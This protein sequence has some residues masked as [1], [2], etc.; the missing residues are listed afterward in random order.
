MKQLKD[1]G[2]KFFPR[3]RGWSG[4]DGAVAVVALVFPARAGLVPAGKS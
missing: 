1:S 2:G 3:E 4:H